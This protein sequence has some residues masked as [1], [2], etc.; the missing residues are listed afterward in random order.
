MSD[1]VGETLDTAEGETIRVPRNLMGFI[2]RSYDTREKVL[3]WMLA[4]FVAIALAWMFQ[5]EVRSWFVPDG[6]LN[7][8]RDDGPQ[9]NQDT[10]TAIPPGGAQQTQAEVYTYNQPPTRQIR[11]AAPPTGA[12]VPGNPSL[13]PMRG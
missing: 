13:P 9:V 12:F 10:A 5:D 11:Y 8:G 1:T 6:D 4:L 2:R 7:A 3:D